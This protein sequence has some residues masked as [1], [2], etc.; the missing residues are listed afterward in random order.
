MVLTDGMSSSTTH[1]S[2][3]ISDGIDESH[4]GDGSPRKSRGRRRTDMSVPADLAEDSETEFA[5]PKAKLEK[6]KKRR[7]PSQKSKKTVGKADPQT[8]KVKEWG[9][10]GRKRK[11]EFLQQNDAFFVSPSYHKTQ[12]EKRREFYENGVLKDYSVEA[13]YYL[14]RE[15]EAKNTRQKR[16]QL[17]LKL[18]CQVC[19]KKMSRLTWNHAFVTHGPDYHKACAICLEKDFPDGLQGHYRKSHFHDLEF[20]CNQCPR[21][22]YDAKALQKHILAH[23]GKPRTARFKCGTCLFLFQSEDALK[24]HVIAVHE[25]ATKTKLSQ[26]MEATTCEFCGKLIQGRC[27]N[28][29]KVN[30]QSHVVRLHTKDKPFKCHLCPREFVTA[31]AYSHHHTRVHTP[32]DVRPFVCTIG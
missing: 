24:E 25:K 20:K 11:Q 10:E 26:E 27:S 28:S 5:K 7:R 18:F 12:A 6:R 31:L 21:A 23:E 3:A 9:E 16:H 22:F 14:H 13:L 30:L 1:D 19:N 4:C 29:L 32:D 17:S 15:R 2:A 8:A